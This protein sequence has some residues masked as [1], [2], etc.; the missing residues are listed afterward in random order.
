MNFDKLIEEIEDFIEEHS[1]EEAILDRL[2]LLEEKLLDRES[3]AEKK[4]R[5]LILSALEVIDN[6]HLILENPGTEVHKKLL[7]EI[8][9]MEDIQKSFLSKKEKSSEEKKQIFF[10]AHQKQMALPPKTEKEELGEQ[11]K[12]MITKPVFDLNPQMKSM[13]P[14]QTF[15]QIKAKSEKQFVT[16]GPGFDH[17]PAMKERKPF[18]S[19]GP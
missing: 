7:K 8:K 4:E 15:E 18:D 1:D 14:K 6:I 2:E 5:S 9:N 19:G 17:H 3:K 11:K 12:F 16:T 10:P 13:A